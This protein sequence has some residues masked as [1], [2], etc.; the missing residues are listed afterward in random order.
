MRLL[1]LSIKNFKGVDEQGVRL[2]FA[3]ITILVG[4]NNAGKSTLIQALHLAREVFCHNNLDPDKLEGCGDTVDLGNF[5]NFVHKHEIDRIVSLRFDIDTDADN[6]P[7][8]TYYDHILPQA[9][10]SN[11][12]QECDA[13]LLRI[14]TVAIEIG[15]RWSRHYNMVIP[16]YQRNYI[17]GH[18]LCTI[19]LG[20]VIGLEL[21]PLDVSS[22]IL[23]WPSNLEHYDAKDSTKGPESSLSQLVAPRTCEEALDA[24]PS[25]LKPLIDLKKFLHS[26]NLPPEE[27]NLLSV[28][29]ENIDSVPLR[30]TSSYF[31]DWSIALPAEIIM[32]SDS[33]GHNLG[34]ANFSIALASSLILGPGQIT[35][36]VLDKFIHLGPL[37]DIPARNYLP[38]KTGIKSRWINGVA[39]WDS[40]SAASPE[41]LKK[42]NYWIAGE[43]GLNS[44]YQIHNKSC[45]QF[46]DYNL[47]GI[48]LHRS[49]AE[50]DFD[51]S[52][53]P[54][55]TKFLLQPPESRLVFKN[56]DSN[57]EVTPYNMGIGIS[58]IIPVVVAACLAKRD[59][60]I[61]I[62]QPEL[63]IHPAWQTVLGDLFLKSVDKDDPPMLLLETHSEHLLLRILRRIRETTNRDLP[64][65]FQPVTAGL[66]SVNYVQINETGSTEINNLPITHDGDFAR[67]WP[68]GFFTERTEELF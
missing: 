53:I 51:E 5:I 25:I 29:Y 67:K 49:L 13:L 1:A 41:E 16:A 61:A 65:R 42:I 19:D 57:V 3:P 35:K 46:D 36:E 37:R 32:K 45:R 50:N 6:W 28:R 64:D 58:Q 12:A 43:D 17:N 31:P 26:C 39:A 4:P 47:L 9:W 24:I 8:P 33:E 56:I 22:L 14:K 63:H 48:M 54:Y 60:V 11:H 27:C 18:H 7:L 59:A 68:H 15:L 34:L 55:L 20:Q 62:E 40:L 2:E 10:Q 30:L 23:G 38:Q 21:P 66:I 44:G 52:L